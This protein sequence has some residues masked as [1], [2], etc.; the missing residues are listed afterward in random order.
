VLKL[1]TQDSTDKNIEKIQT[2]NEIFKDV[3]SDATDLIKDLNWSV[4]T[5]LIF[6]LIIILFGIQTLLYNIET[7]QEQLYI[8]L[9]VA[10][11]MIFAGSVQIMNYFRMRKKYSRLF[12]AKEELLDY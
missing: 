7:L 2:L 10:A 6:G 11:T 3:I 9:F 4:K 5:Y 8:P 12:K 1:D